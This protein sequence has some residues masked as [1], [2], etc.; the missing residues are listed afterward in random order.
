[1]ALGQMHIMLPIL[2]RLKRALFFFGWNDVVGWAMEGG[3]F[4]DVGLASAA[5]GRRSPRRV[6]VRGDDGNS[7]SLG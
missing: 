4:L 3:W 6:A 2:L 5:E 7:T 1:M